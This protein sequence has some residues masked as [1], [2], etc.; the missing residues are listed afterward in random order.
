MSEPQHPRCNPARRFWSRR[1]FLWHSGG[2]LGAIA[3]ADLLR[4]ERLLA[5][6]EPNAAGLPEGRHAGC[7]HHPPRVRRVIQLFMS[8]GVSQ[9][10]SFD[11]KPALAKYHDQSVGK[12]AGIENLF[13]SNPGKWMKSPFAFARYGQSGKLCS[14]I[15]PHI[16]SHV[17]RLAF[18]HSMTADSNSHAPAT[19]LMNTG[20]MRPGYP[21]AGSWVV[22]GL[23]HE[24][25][26]LPAYVVMI[27]RGLPPGHN[28]NWSAGFLPAEYQGTML[29]ASGEPILDLNPPTPTS[30]QTE[31][32]TFDLLA[33]LNADHLAQHPGDGELAAASRPT[34]WP[35]G[36]KPVCQKR[37]I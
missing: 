30:P 28:V 16:A 13:F 23:G 1:D 8:C 9:V 25:D 36:C 7:P 17:D 24:S 14:E 10:D 21:S 4:D 12:L 35:R 5:S 2:G 11:H 37:P 15:F 20:F 27:D 19:F 3:L 18:V 22:Y 26:N 31:R 6:E 34:S 32:E 29:R 33:Q